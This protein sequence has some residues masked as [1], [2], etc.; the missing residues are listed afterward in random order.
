MPA[1]VR[2]VQIRLVHLLCAATF[3]WLGWLM[4]AKGERFASYGETTSY[5]QL[6]LY[7]VAYGMAALLAVTAL[8][9]LALAVLGEREET[10]AEHALHQVEAAETV[11]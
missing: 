10:M 4:V 2:K 5:L 7:P 11:R 8:A 3:A 9:H 1:W 6:P